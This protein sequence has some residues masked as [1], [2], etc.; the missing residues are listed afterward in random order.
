MRCAITG[1][2]GYV[3]SAIAGYFAARGWDIIELVRR[4]T[5]GSTKEFGYRLTD[6][7]SK[8]P[9]QGVNAIVHC[10]YDMRLTKWEDIHRVNV[11]GSIRLL[12]AA[13]T[14]GVERGV[15]ISSLSAFPGC[16][17]YYG[18]AKLMVEEEALRLG[19]AVVRP[20]LVWGDKP[21]GVMGGLTRAVSRGK[22][23]PLI[24]NGTYPQYLIFD[25]DLARLVFE[26]CN[27]SEPRPR[28]V[29]S[30]A[31]PQK[32]SLR[33]LLEKIAARHGRKPVFIPVPWRLLFVGLKTLEAL[34]C[35]SP[36]RSDSLIGLVFQNP[37]P[38]FSLPEFP[39]I[40]FQPFT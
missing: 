25:E 12:E 33:S 24:G 15:F 30:A 1:S 21:G 38:D 6:N 20:G 31:H 22:V 14:H 7:P 3:G 2:A 32:I 39:A 18:K 37:S 35:P 8:I 16:K 36:F 27:G 26:L 5:P 13:R 23:V 40:S 19:Y 4:P 29:I 11:A 28:R 34:H 17:S 9:W 10:A